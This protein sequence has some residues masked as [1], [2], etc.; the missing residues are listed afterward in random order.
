MEDDNALDIIKWLFKDDTKVDFEGI[1]IK[2]DEN[3]VGAEW[4]VIQSFF[5]YY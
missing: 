2:E 1:L 5:Y 3:G 4:M